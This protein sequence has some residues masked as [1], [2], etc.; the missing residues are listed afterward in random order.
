M[1]TWRE[2]ISIRLQGEV[3]PVQNYTTLHKKVATFR[4]SILHVQIFRRQKMEAECTSETLVPT[5]QTTAWCR[6]QQHCTMLHRNPST[7]S[8]N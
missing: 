6:N 3:S 5:Y 1:N 8:G 2:K 4:Q 7:D